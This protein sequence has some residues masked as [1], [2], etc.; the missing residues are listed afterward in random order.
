MNVRIVFSLTE[1]ETGP[2]EKAVA[3][4]KKSFENRGRAVAL[5]RRRHPVLKKAQGD[6]AATWLLRRRTK[7]HNRTM[8]ERHKKNRHPKKWAAMM[9]ARR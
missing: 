3:W 2:G 5:L 4:K 8:K 7:S 6:W 1:L 9:A